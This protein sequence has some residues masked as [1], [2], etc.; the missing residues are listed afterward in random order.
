M[1]A[2]P[3]SC[4]Y[5]RTLIAGQLPNTKENLIQWIRTPQEIEPGTGMPDMGVS[6]KDASH[7]ADYLY[8]PEPFPQ[9]NK[10]FPRKCP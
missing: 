9:F 5:Q 8:N 7:I 3:L 4:F 1:V 2:P 6:A 10:L